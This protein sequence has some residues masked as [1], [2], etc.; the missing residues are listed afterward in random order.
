MAIDFVR[1]EK[2]NDAR[3][4][5]EWFAM[6]ENG[7]DGRGR[8]EAFS[9]RLSGVDPSINSIADSINATWTEIIDD[10]GRYVDAEAYRN[11]EFIAE[12]ANNFTELLRLAR[13]GAEHEAR[14]QK[15]SGP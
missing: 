15:V 9:L 10:D 7:E 13:I 1:L 2:L 6:D 3:N 14:A 12:A 4:R 8:F 11:F 5:R